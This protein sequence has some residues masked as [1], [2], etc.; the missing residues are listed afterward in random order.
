MS[1]GAPPS[2][3][4]IMP[5]SKGFSM[6][7]DKPEKGS[8]LIGSM[9]NSGAELNYGGNCYVSGL[10]DPAQEGVQELSHII[11]IQIYQGCLCSP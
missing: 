1:S 4:S 5:P 3:P 9:Q 11:L 7:M 6:P 8:L 10:Q 2:L